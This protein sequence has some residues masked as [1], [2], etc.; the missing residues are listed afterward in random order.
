ME[1]YRYAA[2]F[3][4]VTKNICHEQPVVF[5]IV[6]AVLVCRLPLSASGG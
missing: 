5:V 2:D 6:L 1:F 3:T 4:F